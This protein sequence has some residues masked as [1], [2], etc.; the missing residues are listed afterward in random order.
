MPCCL[1][2]SL[3]I[4]PV[5]RRV[6][7]DTRD[8]CRAVLLCPCIY[9]LSIDVSYLTHACCAICVSVSVC[10]CLSVCFCLSVSVCLCLGLSA[11]VCL[12]VSVCLCLSACVC[13]SVP[14][15]VCLCLCVCVSSLCCKLMVAITG[16]R[17]E[18]DGTPY[19]RCSTT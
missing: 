3:H 12:P 18:A 7:S 1:A 13:V 17:L 6:L 16:H 5:D 9:R 15:S 10:L 2:M 19:Q 14:V 4:P 11:C 8:T